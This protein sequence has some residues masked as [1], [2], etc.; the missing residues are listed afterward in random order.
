MS[1]TQLCFALFC[2]VSIISSQWIGGM[3][4]TVYA[5]AR[6]GVSFLSANPDLCSA[7]ATEDVDY[8]VI[9]HS[10]ILALHCIHP[11]LS[12]IAQQAL[13]EAYDCLTGCE[14]TLTVMGTTG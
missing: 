9:L 14:V 12:R 2:C 6:Y 1:R 10:V 11:Y 8:P 5:R 13:G 3:Y 4:S 7:L